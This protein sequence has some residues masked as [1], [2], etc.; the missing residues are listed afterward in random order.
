MLN[1]FGLSFCVFVG[2]VE[3]FELRSEPQYMDIATTKK[4]GPFLT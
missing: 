1:F 2:V 3:T 4:A